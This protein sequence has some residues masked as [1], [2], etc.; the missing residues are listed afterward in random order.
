MAHTCSDLPNSRDRGSPCGCLTRSRRR[1]RAGV[2]EE[3]RRWLALSC[4]PALVSSVGCSSVDH[5]VGSG[6]DAACGSGIG[7]SI[8]PNL[9][10]DAGAGSSACPEI[11]QSNLRLWLP[12]SASSS[13]DCTAPLLPGDDRICMIGNRT[14]LLYAPP[15]YNPCEPA[16]LVV[17]AHGALETAAQQA[18]NDS[19]F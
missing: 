6:Q 7:T 16:A 18:G 12:D 11:T 13:T 3:L 2:L 5:A 10:S 8:S 19:I 15:N 17:D 4:L 9:P 1:Q 14:Y